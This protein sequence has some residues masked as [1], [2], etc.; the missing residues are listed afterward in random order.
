[1]FRDGLAHFTHV[2]TVELIEMKFT[3]SMLHESS[4]QML[5]SRETGHSKCRERLCI[6]N[7]D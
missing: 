6:V 3:D 5:Q 2:S 4:L 7:Y 1:M